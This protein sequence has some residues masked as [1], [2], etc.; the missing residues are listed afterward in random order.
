MFVKQL[1]II[2]FCEI[3]K[4]KLKNVKLGN[5]YNLIS[6]F[7]KSEMTTDLTSNLQLT[8]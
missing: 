4:I 5:D 6:K 7:L 8:K 2:L 3:L 1:R